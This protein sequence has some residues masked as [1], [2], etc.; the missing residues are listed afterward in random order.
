LRP[1][2]DLTITISGDFR[3][4]SA[5][6]LTRFLKTYVVIQIL[7]KLAVFSKYKKAKILKIK[8]SDPG[9]AHPTAFE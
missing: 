8:T 1:G 3:Q 2:V 9:E 5:K 6:K 7:Q 4:F